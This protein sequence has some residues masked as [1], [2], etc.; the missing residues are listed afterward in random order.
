MDFLRWWTDHVGLALGTIDDRLQTARAELRV[1]VHGS[2]ELAP[3]I[4]GAEIVD[5]P[6]CNLSIWNLHEHNLTETRG[7][8][9]VDGRV[10]LRLIV[11]GDYAPDRPHELSPSATRYRLSRLPVLRSICVRFAVELR[12]AGWPVDRL[13]PR[14]GQPLAEG[15]PFDEGLYALY[16]IAAAT[17]ADLGD[18]FS[19]DG[20]GRLHSVVGGERARRGTVRD[21]P[22]PACTACSP[23][24][25]T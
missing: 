5:D 8:I 11:L 4:F 24:G 1:S 25:R 23:N 10:P 2:H 20:T 14:L 21:Q 22:L 18:V 17:H 7:R 13:R 9:V 19:P 12:A 15:L 16:R 6:G 3:T